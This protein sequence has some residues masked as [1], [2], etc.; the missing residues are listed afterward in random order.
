M[1]SSKKMIQKKRKILIALISVI[2]IFSN[3]SFSK[4]QEK[5]II[6]AIPDQN[7]EKL[8][9]LYK[10]LAEEISEQLDVKVEYKPVINYPAAV[11]AFRTGY[12]D[13]VW[14]G[15]LTGVQA[16]LQTQGGAKVIAQ[17]EIDAKFHSVFI[18][19]SKSDLPIIKKTS[20]LKLLKGKRFLFGSESSTSGRLMP[21]HYLNQSGVQL[22]D[23][24]GGRPGFSG[25][26]D[27]TIKLVE[28]GTYQAGV[29]NEQVWKARLK[30]GKVNSSKVKVI[31]RTPPYHDYHWLAQT[32]LDK[33][34][35][36]GFTSQLRN[37]L[38]SLSKNNPRQKVI[39]EAFGAEKFITSQS[40][41]YFEIEKIGREIG[42]IK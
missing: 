10:L 9:R 1:N 16:R 23:F 22:S 5:L 41:N 29:L 14:F 34:F 13:L 7:P 11:T 6:G 37:T 24:D 3:K 8:N 39:L 2:S 25:S 35:H 15:G 21:Q 40:K 27:A 30:E 28:S 31:W 38:I 33:R 18:A 26:H 4:P 12:L 20:D 17:R 36:K 19:N 42:K 32:D